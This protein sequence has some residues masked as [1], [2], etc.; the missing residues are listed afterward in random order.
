MPPV[1]GASTEAGGVG[2]SAHGRLRAPRRE[3]SDCEAL[4]TGSGSSRRTPRPTPGSTCRRRSR[5]LPRAMH[6]LA[7][8][9]IVV[10]SGLGASRQERL[11]ADRGVVGAV[12]GGGVRR[13]PA[14]V[15]DLAT[16]IGVG[17]AVGT[18]GAS[19]SG[20]VG[21]EV[22][23]RSIAR[24]AIAISASH[25]NARWAPDLQGFP[26]GRPHSVNSSRRGPVPGRGTPPSPGDARRSPGTPAGGSASRPG[27]RPDP[28]RRR[29]R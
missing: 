15:E 28:C 10:A 6:Q 19:D 17:L 18:V 24:N 23:H 20:G 5:R 7:P 9:P 22:R 12:P 26:L 14:H 1:A 11:C 25:F 16:R 4:G 29:G 27:R 8:A 2:T 3:D 13:T 21:Q